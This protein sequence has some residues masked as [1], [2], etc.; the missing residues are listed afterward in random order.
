MIVVVSLIALK[1][2]RRNKDVYLDV[3]SGALATIRVIIVAIKIR[4]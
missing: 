1:M 2:V 4:E 3:T